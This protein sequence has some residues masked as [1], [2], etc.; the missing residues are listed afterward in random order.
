MKHLKTP[1]ELNE[2]QEN[3]NISDVSDS[4]NISVEKIK[5]ICDGL[6]VSLKNVDLPSMDVIKDKLQNILL[7]DTAPHVLD[8]YTYEM[9]EHAFVFGIIYGA[10]YKG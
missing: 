5:E 10:N 3:L 9:I 6:G 7:D 1:Q 4:K 2:G 8:R